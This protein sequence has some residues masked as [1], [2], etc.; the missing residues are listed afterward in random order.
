M[1]G[2]YLAMGAVF[3]IAMAVIAV[4]PLLL[5]AYGTIPLGESYAAVFGFWLYGMTCIAVGLFISSLTESQVIAA[6][7]TFV[8]LFLGYMM[9]S[10][11]GTCLD[12]WKSADKDIGLLRSVHTVK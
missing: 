2:K 5:L 8:A 10:I 1:V 9:S 11:N 6:V 12:K 4:T 7:L 3:S